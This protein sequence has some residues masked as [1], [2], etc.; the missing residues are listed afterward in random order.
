MSSSQC[1]MASFF[2]A[3]SI[4]MKY[5]STKQQRKTRILFL[6]VRMI[7]HHDV[8]LCTAF[9]NV[10]INKRKSKE[11]RNVFLSSIHCLLDHD[12][13]SYLHLWLYTYEMNDQGDREDVRACNNAGVRPTSGIRTDW[14]S[15]YM[16]WDEDEQ[17]QVPRVVKRASYHSQRHQN[18]PVS[19]FYEIN[20]GRASSGAARLTNVLF[21]HFFQWHESIGKRLAKK[22]SCI[23]QVPDFQMLPGEGLCLYRRGSY[24]RVHV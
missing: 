4:H 14:F 19:L 11:R 21:C 10:K 16:K 18:L 24:P 6:H 8:G 23:F 5:T 2:A 22:C 17:V 9:V 1:T 7:L 13:S 15:F 3:L 20:G 12:I